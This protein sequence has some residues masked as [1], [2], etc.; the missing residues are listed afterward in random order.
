[1]HVGLKEFHRIINFM[2]KSYF[3]ARGTVVSLSTWWSTCPKLKWDDIFEVQRNPKCKPPAGENATSMIIYFIRLNYIPGC[4]TLWQ[5]KSHTRGPI[6]PG[7]S[8]SMLPCLASCCTGFTIRLPP[9]ESTG[10]TLIGSRTLARGSG[11]L[12]PLQDME[13][14][15]SYV[16]RRFNTKFKLNILSSLIN[17]QTNKILLAKNATVC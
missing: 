10:L 15:N 5:C 13:I 6:T 16:H 9:P 7:S 17:K 14:L 4:W 1:M 2:I 12:A 8:P 11:M 3:G